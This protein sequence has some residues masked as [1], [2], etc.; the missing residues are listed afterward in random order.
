MTWLGSTVTP[1]RANVCSRA[2]R[3][4]TGVLK[5]AP[6]LKLLLTIRQ[7]QVQQHSGSGTHPALL[8]APPGVWYDQAL[9]PR[10]PE[11]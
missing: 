8:R 1:A 2:E 4:R 10:P 6:S 9:V 7:P 5:C 11:A 3:V